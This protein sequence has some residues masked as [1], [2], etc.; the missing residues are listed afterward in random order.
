MWIRWLFAEGQQNVNQNPVN[1]SI[2]MYLSCLWQP[3]VCS[4]KMLAEET[5]FVAKRQ[6]I[7]MPGTEEELW[8]E[9]SSQAGEEEGK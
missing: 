9:S 3:E 4:Q 5:Q 8:M 6:R 7:A 2:K 1:V